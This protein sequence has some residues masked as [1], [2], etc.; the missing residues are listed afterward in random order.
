MRQDGGG[1]L[2]LSSGMERGRCGDGITLACV[3]RFLTMSA[4]AF[5]VLALHFLLSAV[6]LWSSMRLEVCVCV[7]GV[8]V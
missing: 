7:E 5:R 2:D 1:S 8:R 6:L 3:Q 4:E